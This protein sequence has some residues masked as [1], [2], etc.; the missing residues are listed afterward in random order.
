MRLCA[1]AVVWVSV[2]CTTFLCGGCAVGGANNFAFGGL[3]YRAGTRFYG[4]AFF[5]KSDRILTDFAVKAVVSFAC[6]TL[7]VFAAQLV[8]ELGV[9]G[10][11]VGDC[12]V[13]FG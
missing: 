2:G 1:G 13:V 7:S 9:C 12:V 10:D 6:E 3:R 4:V 5:R 8:A 11:E